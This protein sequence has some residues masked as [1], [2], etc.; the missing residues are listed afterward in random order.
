MPMRSQPCSCSLGLT[1]HRG[2]VCGHLSSQA[3]HAM[4][5]YPPPPPSFPTF[6]MFQLGTCSQRCEVE[7][8]NMTLQE[9]SL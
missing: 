2:M 9:A 8:E 6:I 1:F 5:P 4:G 7:G 3:A